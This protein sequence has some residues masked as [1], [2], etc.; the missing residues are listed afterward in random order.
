MSLN[1]NLI[2]ESFD[3]VKPHADDVVA[4]FYDTL[5]ANHPEAKGLFKSVDMEEQKKALI[6]ALVHCVDNI[7]DEG[8]LTKYLKSLGGRHVRYGVEEGHYAWVGEA[9]LQTFEYFFDE[10]WTAEIED[11]WTQLY[12]FMSD[13]MKL[14]AKEQ[15]PETFELVEEEPLPAGTL[16]D[17]AKEHAQTMFKKALME[18][19]NGPLMDIARA[20]VRNLLKKTLEREVEIE[21]ASFGQTRQEVDSVNPAKNVKLPNGKPKN[22]VGPKKPN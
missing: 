14:G 19:L 11:A 2:V 7:N 4:Y 16:T 5:F 3:A 22:S 10:S 8:H 12:T 21:L 13:T 17:I 15:Q 18:E 1:K 20:E 9:L 6:G